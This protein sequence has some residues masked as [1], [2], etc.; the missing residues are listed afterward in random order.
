MSFISAAFVSGTLSTITAP[1]AIRPI[2]LM[3]LTT[4]ARYSQTPLHEHVVKHAGQHVRVVEYDYYECAYH[5]GCI[6]YRNYISTNSLSIRKTSAESRPTD[7]V[8]TSIEP[9]KN[10]SL[11]RPA[12][13]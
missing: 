11:H 5:V 8:P 10:F 2:S 4:M 9:I 13:I 7:T 12:T 3:G 6:R 1:P